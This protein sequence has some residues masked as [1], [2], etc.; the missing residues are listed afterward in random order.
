MRTLV[1]AVALLCSTLFSCSKK[2]ESVPEVI[3]P[4]A[5]GFTDYTIQAGKQFADQNGYIPV[6]L[7]SLK[8]IVKF[9]ST[10][11]YATK[12]PANQGDINKLYGFSDNNALHQDFSSRFGWRWVNK[13]LNLQAYIYN[14]SIRQYTDLG[15]IEIGPEYNCAINVKEK[16]YEFV[17]NGKITTMP[18]TSTT[19]TAVGYMLYPYFGGDELAPHLFHIFIKPL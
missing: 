15:N 11:I 2:E 3:T 1:C 10:A 8:F 18:R 14:N 6:S 17:L 7:T 4:V 16:L 9:D 12:D 13:R 5:K 19:P